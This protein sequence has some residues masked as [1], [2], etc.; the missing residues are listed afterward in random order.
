MSN[1][2]SSPLE[3]LS[4]EKLAQRKRN[5]L[6][7]ASVLLGIMLLGLAAG[8]YDE[9]VTG[10]DENH[11]LIFSIAVGPASAFYYN[12]HQQAKIELQRRVNQAT[13]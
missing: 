13:N 10:D 2:L 12:K 6:I 5:M 11:Y 9:L 3:G 1:Q 4:D 8:L 7:I